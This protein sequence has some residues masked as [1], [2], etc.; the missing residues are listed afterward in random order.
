MALGPTCLRITLL[1][2]GVANQEETL[3]VLGGWLN[4]PLLY[5]ILYS[6]SSLFLIHS[7][8][9]F[10][11]ASSPFML[12]S[13]WMILYNKAFTVLVICYWLPVIDFHCQ[14]WPYPALCLRWHLPTAGLSRPAGKTWL[15]NTF[16]NVCHSEGKMKSDIDYWVWLWLTIFYYP[17]F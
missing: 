13:A 11:S 12:H 16:P 9:K 6:T 4:E 8:S 5:L 1:I 2:H 7:H 3:P 14:S 15:V 17:V 10:L